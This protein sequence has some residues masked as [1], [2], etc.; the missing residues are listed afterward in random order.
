[1]HLIALKMLTGDRAKYLGLI[2]AIAFCT[3]LLENQTSIFGGILRRTGSQILDV[4]DAD[5]W[6]MDPKVQFIDEHIDHP[7]RVLLRHIII[8]ILREQNALPTVFT[9]N[10]TLHH[11]PRSRSSR[12]LTQTAFSHSL[13]PKRN[14][15]LPPLGANCGRGCMP[16]IG[17]S[18]YDFSIR[19]NSTR[20]GPNAPSEKGVSPS[21]VSTPK[22]P[23]AA[24]SIRRSP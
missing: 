2:F 3:F 24:R 14:F 22:T 20:V 4:T 6:V 23:R 15:E 13:D 19:I 7:D 1:M 11:N 16:A 18:G 17:P 5:I 8:Q 21:P 10:E 12:I 9:L